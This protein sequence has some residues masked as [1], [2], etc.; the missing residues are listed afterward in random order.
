MF[1]VVR[2]NAFDVTL[3]GLGYRDREVDVGGTRGGDRDVRGPRR[4]GSR[5][6]GRFSSQPGLSDIVQCFSLVPN[7]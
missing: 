4:S 7:Q 3:Q 5:M 6:F 2:R 1:L